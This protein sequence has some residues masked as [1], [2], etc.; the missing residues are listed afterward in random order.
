MILKVI[1]V[2]VKRLNYSKWLLDDNVKNLYIF[3]T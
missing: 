3:H 2:K 1:I